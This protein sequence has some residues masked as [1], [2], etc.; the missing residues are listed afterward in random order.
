MHVG[1]HAHIWATVRVTDVVFL[2]IQVEDPLKIWVF[3]H[4]EY[5]AHR[6]MVTNGVRSIFLESTLDERDFDLCLPKLTEH[7][8]DMRY[9]QSGANGTHPGII[10]VLSYTLREKR[11][12]VARSLHLE[13]HA[14]P[15]LK[16]QLFVDMSVRTAVV[17]EDFCLFKIS[18]GRKRSIAIFWFCDIV[19]VGMF[20]RT[21]EVRSWGNVH[22][23]L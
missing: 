8:L 18:S 3:D 21:V 5:F 11:M 22:W 2:R 9:L 13:V 20:S 14:I 23:A 1:P 12:H 16:P 19:P 4:A 6:R 7:P 17:D 10:H 15:T